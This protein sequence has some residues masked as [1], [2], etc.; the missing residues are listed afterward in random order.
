MYEPVKTKEEAIREKIEILKDFG[1]IPRKS[2][3]S[4]NVMVNRFLQAMLDDPHTDYQI[5]LDRVTRQA[6]SL[7]LDRVEERDNAINNIHNKKKR[8]RKDGTK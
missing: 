1:V 7:Y 5:V 2:I 4:E 8:T 3:V 6:I